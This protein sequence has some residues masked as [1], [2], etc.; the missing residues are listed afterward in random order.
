VA[1]ELAWTGLFAVLGFVSTSSA[2]TTE[3]STKSMSFRCVALK[4]IAILLATS[5]VTSCAT[6]S[7]ASKSGT[8]YVNTKGQ[9]EPVPSEWVATTEGKFAH[10]IE[11]PQ[12]LP[13]DSGYRRGMSSEQYFDHLCKNEAG[14]FI[15][16]TVE[17]V[18][19]FYFARP[20]TRP[21]DD[22]LQDRY[23]LEA[24]EIERT[25]QLIPAT[26]A[27][28]ATAFV[29]PPSRLF[30]FIE[31]P[32]PV[33]GNGK[34]YV[35]AFDYLPGKFRTEVEPVSELRSAYGL[36]W[37]GIKRPHD[38]EL[39]IAGSE[40][41]VFDLKTN[42]VLAVRRDYARTGFTRNTPDGIWWLNAQGCSNVL[43]RDNLTSRFYQFVIKALT[44]HLTRLK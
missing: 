15:Y 11:L 21:T 6:N 2:F 44:P 29:A 10:S 1:V 8:E 4:S 23:K 13:R 28:R 36:I 24:P 5:L 33:V 38:R 37:R 35:R 22:D 19:G 27:A 25:Y 7:T 17:A 31:E 18:D 30:Q 26:P 40:W 9:P 32:N 42:E 3:L 12:P 16:K 34:P 39:G 41:I 43:P 14:D 20:P